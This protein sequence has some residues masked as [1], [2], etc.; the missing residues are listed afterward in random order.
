[1]ISSG[2]SGGPIVDQNNV[3]IGT[4]SWGA[5]CAREGKPGVY[6]RVSAVKRW[7]EEQICDFS[8]HPPYACLEHEQTNVVTASPTAEEEPPEHEQTN[9]VTAPPTAEDE[10]PPEEK[11]AIRVDIMYDQCPH[12]T[13]WYLMKVDPDSDEVIEHIYSMDQGDLSYS[14]QLISVEL[15]NLTHGSYA[16]EIFDAFEDGI[17]CE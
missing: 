8:T 9:V 2:D 17:C 7:I 12:E 3:L 1:M 16:F 4:I 15:K 5:G 13:S 10:P 14:E 6:A 11:V